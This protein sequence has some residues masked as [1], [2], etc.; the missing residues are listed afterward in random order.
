[1]LREILAR[2]IGPPP[3]DNYFW[4]L[5]R[6]YFDIEEGTARSIFSRARSLLK[7]DLLGQRAPLCRWRHAVNELEEFV[8]ID[9]AAGNYRDDRAA[10]GFAAQ[11]RRH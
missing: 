8:E 10:S 7:T 1:M 4:R 9:V 3:G 11:S 5:R 2:W 6:P